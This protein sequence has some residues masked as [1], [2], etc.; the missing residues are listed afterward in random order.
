[1]LG[2]AGE[3]IQGRL[4]R[5]KQLKL[6]VGKRI[7]KAFDSEETEL[8]TERAKKSRSPHMYL[9]YMFARNAGLRDTEIKTL[10]WTQIN[11]TAKTVQVGRANTDAVERRIV[12]LNSELFEAV[13]VHRVGYTKKFDE[14]K[15]EWYVFPCGKPRPSDPTR[16]VTSLKT[17]WKNMRIEGFASSLVQPRGK[18]M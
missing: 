5:K 13:I 17:A 2:D 6:A 12:P 3:V 8:L 14:A 15:D 4:K 18:A 9:A 1:M 11:L 10:T 7:G 16:H